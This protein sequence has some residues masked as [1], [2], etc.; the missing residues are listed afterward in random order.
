MLR[1]ADVLWYSRFV[2][3]LGAA[4]LLV[5]AIAGHASGV[6]GVLA[7]LFLGGG[8]IIFL[9]ALALEG[10]QSGRAPDAP[11][12]GESGVPEETETAGGQPDEVPAGEGPAS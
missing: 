3:W 11:S 9:A 7:M 5:E 10:I 2:L 12:L 4:M 1:T 8:F 6:V